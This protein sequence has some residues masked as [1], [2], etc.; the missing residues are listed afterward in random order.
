MSMSGKLKWKW[1]HLL[2]GALVAPSVMAATPG[3]VLDTPALGSDKAAL[4]LLLDVATAG[5]RV[6]AVGTRGH[7]VYSDD[8]GKSWDQSQVPVS[9]MLTAVSFADANNGWAVGHGAAVLRTRDGGLT[10]SRIFDGRQANEYVIEDARQVVADL[11]SRLEA[12]SEDVAADLETQ[13][14]EA[15][16]ALEDAQ[17]D[18]ESG[19]AKPLLDV[20]FANA[21]E[22]YV[23]GAYGMVFRT[24]DGGDT[25]QYWSPRL[26]NPDR[27]HL[28]AI[29]RVEGAGLFIVGEA[30]QVFRSRDGGLTWTTL[31]SLYDGS[32][33][34]VIGTST[35]G[36]VLAFGLRGNVYLSEDGGDTWTEVAQEITETL[37]AGTVGVDGRVILVGNGGMLLL[38]Q[39]GGRTFS[40]HPREDRVSLTGVLQSSADRLLLVGESGVSVIRGISQLN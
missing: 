3:D 20:W 33:F 19:A 22:G 12:A 13:L 23:V 24:I 14:E 6:V 30:G 37:T 38:S 39:D 28:N 16:F 15:T 34:G 27:F 25:W 17:A 31:E 1:S 2:L 8:Q 29:S 18:S 36:E 7:I 10:W 21:S 9:V 40:A 4:S 32:F 5:E 11:E 26:D 35:P